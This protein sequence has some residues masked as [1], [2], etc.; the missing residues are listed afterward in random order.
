MQ[1]ILSGSNAEW[2]ENILGEDGEPVPTQWKALLDSETIGINRRVVTASESG[3]RSNENKQN[4]VNALLKAYRELGHLYANINPLG[5]YMPPNLRY[6]WITQHGTGRELDPASYGLDESDMDKLYDAPESFPKPQATLRQIINR[7]D[8]VYAGPMGSEFLHIRNRPMRRW[9]IEQIESRE[10]LKPWSVEELQRWQRDLIRAE[11]FESFI[12]SRFT[13]QKR[14]SL[15]GTEV[16]IPA[17]RYLFTEAGNRNVREIIMGMAHR[18]RLNVL[19][20]AM[21]KPASEIFAMFAG[22]YVPHSYGG[23][24]DVKYHIG[25]STDF[26]L[27]DGRSIHLS[28]VANPSH[29]EA[30]D[31]VVQGKA[32]GTQRLRGDSTRKKVLPVLLHGDAAFSGQGVVA[33]TFNMSQLRGYRTGGTIHIVINNQIGF[34]TSPQFAR[35]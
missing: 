26:D 12:H 17:L 34:T 11:E 4:R 23:S 33:E 2:L 6:A 25:Q 31:P 18:G 24:G 16:L 9:L 10:R 3:E 28:L 14:F 32:R 35:S 29:L 22:H 27:G 8:V 21:K 15:E 5:S 1:E 19:T 13:G 20:N 7:L 30:V